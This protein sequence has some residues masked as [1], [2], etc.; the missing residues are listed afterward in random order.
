M[1]DQ[2]AVNTAL[3]AAIA[4]FEHI[5]VA[6][7]S[8]A[9]PYARNMAGF[10]LYDLI[11]DVSMRTVLFEAMRDGKFQ[12]AAGIG[13]NSADQIAAYAQHY[14][15]QDFPDFTTL[16][17]DGILGMLR[18]HT[19]GVDCSGFVFHVLAHVSETLQIPAI[20][21]DL[22]W[23]DSRHTVYQAGTSVFATSAHVVITEWQDVRPGDLAIQHSEHEGYHHLGIIFERE[24][25]LHLAQSSVTTPHDGVT[26]YPIQESAGGPIRFDMIPHTIGLSWQD[27]VERG[28]VAI[29]RLNALT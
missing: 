8:F 4:Q 7:Q 23:T 14:L 19:V 1:I 26:S 20:L 12:L 10:T 13:K 17:P 9:A 24:G 11:P 22:G 15:E 16:T 28:E 27:Y 29:I 2:T 25:K 18:R 21:D 6:S 5:T 3:A